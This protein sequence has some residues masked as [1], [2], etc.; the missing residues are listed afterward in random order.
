M[1]ATGREAKEEDMEQVACT[2]NRT[3][4]TERC[5][6]WQDVARR[7]FLERTETEQGLRLGF[8]ND[9]GVEAELHELAA[10]ERECCAFADWAVAADGDRAVLEVS[11]TSDEAVAAVRGMFRP[12]TG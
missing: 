11:G 6:R 4:M 7:A 5:G 12:L 1:P 2:L 8:R 3:R 9:P 10:L